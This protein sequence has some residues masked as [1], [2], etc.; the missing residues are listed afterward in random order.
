MNNVFQRIIGLLV[1]TMISLVFATL[2]HA[3]SFDCSKAATNVEKIV[4][5]DT[6]LSQLD[7]DLNVAYKAALQKNEKQA[8]AIRQSQ[9]QWIKTRNDCQ[10]ST[11]LTQS[12]QQRIYRTASSSR[13]ET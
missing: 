7:D 3:A 8:V 5:G 10:D 13:A 12:Y 11:C 6:A 2:T 9:K 4:C 1:V